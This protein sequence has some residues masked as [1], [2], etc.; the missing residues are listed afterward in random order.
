MREEGRKT[1]VLG[2]E[3]WGSKPSFIT[4]WRSLL[5]KSL[6]LSEHHFPICKMGIV[7]L[8]IEHHLLGA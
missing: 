1:R 5:G 7:Y 4:Y 8:L 2:S 6:N 3:A